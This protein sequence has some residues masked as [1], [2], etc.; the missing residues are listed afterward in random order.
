M[1]TRFGSVSRP[2]SS[3]SKSVVM[4]CTTRVSLPLFLT[5]L[6]P[7]A[8][9]SIEVFCQLYYV[10]R[11]TSITSPGKSATCREPSPAP[12][13]RPPKAEL[14]GRGSQTEW[15]RETTGRRH[16]SQAT[17]TPDHARRQGCHTP[18]QTW[19]PRHRSAGRKLRSEEHTSELQSRFDLV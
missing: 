11:Q 18:P 15:P 3:E 17:P 12:W 6:A 1:A 7:V 14:P 2:I 8:K 13:P 16:P 9:T 19:R 5:P 4:H 10:S